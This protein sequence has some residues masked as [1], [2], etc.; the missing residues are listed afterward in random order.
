VRAQTWVSKKA[1]TIDNPVLLG[2]SPNFL[3]LK[4]EFKNAFWKQGMVIHNCNSSTLKTDV[5]RS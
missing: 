1:L 3:H 2:E 5:G 4:N